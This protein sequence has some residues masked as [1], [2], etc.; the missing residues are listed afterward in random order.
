MCRA[1]G[2]IVITSADTD[3]GIPTAARCP[4]G[5]TWTLPDGDPHADTLPAWATSHEAPADRRRAARY[6]P[7]HAMTREEYH[8]TARIPAE[9]LGPSGQRRI[10]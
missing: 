2:T 5:A 3:R 4:C 9:R 10:P 6:A 7:E 1:T 8:E